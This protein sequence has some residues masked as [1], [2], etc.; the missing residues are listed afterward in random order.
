MG[1]GG[2][3]IVDTVTGG[4]SDL[5]DSVRD[6]PLNALSTAAGQVTGTQLATGTLQTGT[7]IRNDQREQAAGMAAKDEAKRM[8]AERRAADAAVKDTDPLALE[9]R[10]RA[11]VA[12]NRGREGSILTGGTSLGSDDVARKV[13]L[14]M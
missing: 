2:G 4:A 13:L 8:A 6:D 7:R 9:R 12:G 5:W 1:S 3:N 14:G 10:R 11:A